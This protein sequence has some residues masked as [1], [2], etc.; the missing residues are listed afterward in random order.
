MSSAS[1]KKGHDFIDTLFQKLEISF[2]V[3]KEDLSRIPKT[4][5]FIVVSNHPFGGLDDL[6]L[7]RIFSGIRPD[8]KIFSNPILQKFGGLDEYVL[9]GTAFSSSG[10]H[11][12]TPGQIMGVVRH[13]QSGGALGIFPSGKVSGYDLN[14]NDITDKQWGPTVL[15]FIK[16][17]NVP[18]IPVYFKGSN[19]LFF[20]LLGMIHPS[21]QAFKL[22]SELLNKK[23]SSIELRIGF[24]IPLKDQEEFDDIS[25]YGRYLRAKTY[26][27]GTSLEIRKFFT[28][29]DEHLPVAEEIAAPIPTDLLEAEIKSLGEQHLLFDMEPFSVYCS[30]AADIPNIILEL[31]RLREETF[32]LVGEGTNKKI[33]LDEYDLYYR[34]LFIWDREA[35]RIV[36]AY[37]IGM[38]AEIIE[39]YGIKGFYLASLWKISE[40]FRPIMSASIELGRSFIVSDYQKKPLSLYG[41]WKGILYFLLKHPEYQYLIGP[42]SISN[43]FSKFS[44][45]LMI[46]YIMQHY[47]DYTL[48]RYVKPRNEFISDTGN[49]D[50]EILLEEAKDL[51]KFDKCIRDVDFEDSG[52]PILLK[53]YLSLNGK[54]IAF[55]L[56]Q[57]FNDA[58]DGLLVLDL[59]DVPQ[60]V[61]ASLSKELEDSSILDRFNNGPNAMHRS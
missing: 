48:S 29:V 50:V 23:H 38:G 55:N 17:S 32:R 7:L 24:P 30:P 45:S 49:V 11:R 33:D 2:E 1:D 46:E 47:F 37:R 28:P 4:G 53:K 14:S 5:P 9:P 18:V 35:S 44:R 51:S 12:S 27:L 16:N 42:V 10:R 31:G 41:L 40:G 22:P 43:R 13:L 39:E 21:L 25:R 36:G 57:K 26:A 54:I 34:H 6:I 60:Q 19:S 58:L 15:R 3:K 56:D 8:F 61:I 52:M 20:Q 59:M